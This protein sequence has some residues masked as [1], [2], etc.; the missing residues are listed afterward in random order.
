VKKFTEKR[1][2]MIQKVAKILALAEDPAAT[3]GERTSAHIKALEIMN[4]WHVHESEIPESETETQVIKRHTWINEG[5]SSRV[6]VQYLLNSVT[7]MF[8]GTYCWDSDWRKC[9]D[10][11]GRVTKCREGRHQCRGHKVQVYTVFATDRA[12]QD[13]QLWIDHLF[14]QMRIDQMRAKPASHMSYAQ[15][16]ALSVCHRLRQLIKEQ[17]DPDVSSMFA[18]ACRSADDVMRDAFPH[19]NSPRK[20]KVADGGSFS[21]GSSSG[22]SATLP[23]KSVAKSYQRQL[24]A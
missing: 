23:H 3:E 18:L 20:A 7:E 1:A 13:I 5:R 22:M 19:M 10:E 14:V 11:D 15:G 9:L 24:N 2:D 6:G 4:E 16:W 21:R 12:F 8:G 17:R